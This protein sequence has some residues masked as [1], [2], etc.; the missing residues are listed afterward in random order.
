MAPPS[1]SSARLK[2]EF[3]MRWLHDNEL[4]VKSTCT[5][6]NAKHTAA[7]SI[8]G[9]MHTMMLATNF[10][11]GINPINT[12]TA[13][14]VTLLKPYGWVRFLFS[15]SDR[16]LHHLSST[17]RNLDNCHGKKLTP[18]WIVWV[19]CIL[20]LWIAFPMN[21]AGNSTPP[22]LPSVNLCVW[23]STKYYH[24]V[25]GAHIMNLLCSRVYWIDRNGWVMLCSK[26]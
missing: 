21:S 24:F 25:R 6:C 26:P 19:V 11:S 18:V 1:P 10:A 5:C 8:G 4:S 14:S 16:G 13:H 23:T 3:S 9:C 22:K 20:P 17:R 12:V 15:A 7:Q 2:R